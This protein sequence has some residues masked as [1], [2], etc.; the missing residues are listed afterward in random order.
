MSDT[1]ETTVETRPATLKDLQ[2]ARLFRDTLRE[3]AD[4][5]R[6]AETNLELDNLCDQYTGYLMTE[7]LK[8]PKVPPEI[9]AAYPGAT[10]VLDSDSSTD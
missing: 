7:R 2:E 9:A 8:L 10:F 3:F 4:K 6:S 1:P 5:A